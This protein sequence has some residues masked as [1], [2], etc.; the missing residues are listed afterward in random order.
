MNRRF[1]HHFF[2]DLQTLCKLNI[3]KMQ[4]VTLAQEVYCFGHRNHLEKEDIDAPEE[5]PPSPRSSEM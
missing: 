2:V 3:V 4:S 1:S 5:S